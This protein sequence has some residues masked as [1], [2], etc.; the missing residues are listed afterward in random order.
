MKLSDIHLENLK[1]ELEELLRGGFAPNVILLKEFNYNKTGIILDG[2]HFSA[3]ML[4]GHIRWRHQVFLEFMRNP[5]EPVELWP[6]T[7]WPENHQPK[8][9]KEWF[10]AI[11]K[12]ESELEEMITIVLDIKT[13]LFSEN[14]GKSILCGV[15]TVIHH[16]GYHIGQ[17][18]TIGR[19]L[20]VW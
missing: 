15:I 8:S 14:N 3:W 11:A 13:D 9:E 20:D 5:N 6:P 19:Q 10:E 7:Y 2:L 12:Y 16:T 17:L 1:F 4:L 18:K